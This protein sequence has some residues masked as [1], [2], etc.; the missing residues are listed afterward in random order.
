MASDN[1]TVTY[2]SLGRIHIITYMSGQTITYTYD[3]DG[4]RTE[5]VTTS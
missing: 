1:F 5:V 4:N 2:D 3:D